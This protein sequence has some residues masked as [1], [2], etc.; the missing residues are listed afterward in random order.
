M[1]SHKFG[2]LCPPPILLVIIKL[3]FYLHL[4]HIVWH[5]FLTQPP[6]LAWRH[7]WMLLYKLRKQC[8]LD[9]IPEPLYWEHF[10]PSCY[11]PEHCPW[12]GPD[13]ILHGWRKWPAGCH[14][15][16]PGT[17][18]FG[19]PV[20]QIVPDVGR[21]ILHHEDDGFR[22]RTEKNWKK[23]WLLIRAKSMHRIRGAELLK[24]RVPNFCMIN[25]ARKIPGRLCKDFQR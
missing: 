22:F 21:M 1:T 18:D 12:P 16:R 11:E 3:L 4:L 9:I 23:K 13:S 19:F 5:K 6:L 7:L 20:L 2:L 8:I 14:C 25:I 17:K 10:F 15:H 24:L